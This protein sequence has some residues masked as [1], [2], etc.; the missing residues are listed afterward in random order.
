MARRRSGPIEP[1]RCRPAARSDCI[2]QE[3][4]EQRAVRHIDDESSGWRRRRAG[5][6]CNAPAPAARPDL[7][8]S[9]IASRTMSAISAASR[10]PMFRPCAPIGGSTWAASPTSA[11]RCCGKSSGLLDRQ[12]KQMTSRFDPDAAENGMRLV[13]RGLGQFIVAR[14]P[15]A[16]RLPWARRP[17]PRCSGCRAA[18]RTRRDLAACETRWRYFDGAANG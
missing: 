3:I 6:N 4:A 11:M 12:R 5:P 15:S 9:H 16:A 14:A 7:R 17:T 10:N 18:A 2:G 1:I 8:P 13:F